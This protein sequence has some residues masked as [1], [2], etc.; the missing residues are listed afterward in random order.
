MIFKIGELWL[1][2]QN[3]AK[4]YYFH[5]C[6]TVETGLSLTVCSLLSSAVHKSKCDHRHEHSE[7][8]KFFFVFF[9]TK[10][11]DILPQDKL[12]QAPPQPH[13]LAQPWRLSS[14]LWLC[15]SFVPWCLDLSLVS[16]SSRADMLVTG[17][18]FSLIVTILH[19]S[20]GATGCPLGITLTST[21]ITL[22]SHQSKRTVWSV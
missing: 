19:F 4:F 11:H 20:E 7:A 6:L 15:Q 3:K 17:T 22:I 12:L 16:S 10:L 21:L 14:L 1:F 13:P 8:L 5:F 18:T 2:G 9:L